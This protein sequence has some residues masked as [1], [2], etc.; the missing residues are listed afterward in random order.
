MPVKGIEILLDA[1]QMLSQ[2]HDSLRLLVVGDN[3][4]EYGCEMEKKAAQSTNSDKIHFTGKAKIFR[5]DQSISDIN[6]QTGKGIQIWNHGIVFQSHIAGKAND[7]NW[8]H[9]NYEFFRKILNKLKNNYD[10]N[11]IRYEE[12]L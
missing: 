10:L 4:N 1:F 2:N 5:G 9:K 11:F 8:T 7:N 6:S 12:L 3:D